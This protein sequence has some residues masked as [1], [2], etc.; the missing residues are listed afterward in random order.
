MVDV[1]ESMNKWWK[2]KCVVKRC[3]KNWLPIWRVVEMSHLNGTKMWMNL[4]GFKMHSKR[5]VTPHCVFKYYQVIRMFGALLLVKSFKL[6]LLSI[7]LALIL[8]LSILS[9]HS[10]HYYIWIYRYVKVIDSTKN[11][12]AAKLFI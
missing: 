4:C 2:E 1:C 10:F 5:E 12:I 7:K 6:I 8:N 11:F 3:E 9:L